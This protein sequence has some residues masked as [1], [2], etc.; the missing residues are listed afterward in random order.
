MA[1]LSGVLGDITG[2]NQQ[3]D[4]ATQAA[5]TESNASEYAANLTAQAQKQLVADLAPYSALG[6]TASPAIL[7]MLGINNAGQSTGNTA[8]TTPFSFNASNLDQTPGYQFTQQQGNKAVNNQAAASGLTM[9]GAQLKGIDSYNTGLADQ[10]YN[11]QYSNA[12]NTYNTNYNV[13]QN[14]LQSLM[15]LLGV[16]QNS[17]A[18]TGVSGVSSAGS[19]GNQLTAGATATAAGQTAAGNSQ[20]SYLNSLMGLGTSAAS[21]YAL[22]ALA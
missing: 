18:Q 19:V 1:L 16:G 2:T 9:S 22:A 13:Q 10:T 14:K 7:Q 17:A 20:S 8:L 11:Q 15:S 21:I 5:S 4:A 3:A 6:Q 12:L